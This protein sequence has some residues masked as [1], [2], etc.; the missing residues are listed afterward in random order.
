VRDPQLAEERNSAKGDQSDAKIP[1]TR[2]EIGLG[3]TP[4]TEKRKEE[5]VYPDSG[6]GKKMKLPGPTKKKTQGHLPEGE[7]GTKSTWQRGFI[8]QGLGPLGFFLETA[9]SK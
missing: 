4:S 5:L 3:D 9:R 6:E 1:L 2:D 8:I 7:V